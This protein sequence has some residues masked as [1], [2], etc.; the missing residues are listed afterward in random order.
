MWSMRA[1][2]HPAQHAVFLADPLPTPSSKAAKEWSC[3]R[4]AL[5]QNVGS[6]DTTDY[7]GNAL[8][9]ADQGFLGQ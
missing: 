5:Q 3:H 2:A 8:M 9:A 7:Q 6:I 4:L 1:S